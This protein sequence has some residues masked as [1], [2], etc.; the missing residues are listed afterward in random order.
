MEPPSAIGAGVSE[1]V[2]TGTR[3]PL[4]DKNVKGRSW[5]RVSVDAVGDNEYRRAQ[6]IGHADYQLQRLALGVLRAYTSDAG[7]RG[8]APHP[9]PLTISVAVLSFRRARERAYVRA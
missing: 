7:A 9:N 4:T 5:D 8:A 2:K 3:L 1:I 6:G